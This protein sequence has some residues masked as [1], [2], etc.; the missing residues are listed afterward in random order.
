MYQQAGYG[1]MVY[2]KKV[3]QRW[4]RKV[5]E[6]IKLYSEN[7][8]DLYRIAYYYM[9]NKAEAEDAV[10]DAVL[11]AYENFNSLR[12]RDA[13]RGWIIKILVNTCK[14]RMK[15][16][17]GKDEVLIK[18]EK[19]DD[20]EVKEEVILSHEPDYT[21]RLAVQA[22]MSVLSEQERMIVALYVLGGYKGEEISQILQLKHSTVRSKYH[23]AL[24]KMKKQL[25]I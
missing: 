25:E 8:K 1:I 23:R 17:Y 2:Q 20:G 9:G 16:W 13:F 6:F 14:K 10:G 3:I 11:S 15:S 24:G 21:D 7:Y 12:E 4:V 22:A 5:D 18:E 19:S